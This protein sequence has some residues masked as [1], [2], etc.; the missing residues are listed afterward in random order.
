MNIALSRQA[1][2]RQHGFTLTE[3]M[4]T[5]AVMAVLAVVALPRLM[6]PLTEARMRSVAVEFVDS[7]SLARS[8]AASRRRTVVLCP[9]SSSTGTCQT[10][11]TNWNAGWLL[12]VD[13]NNNDTLDTTETR[14]L[15]HG[16]LPAALTIGGGTTGTAAIA[17]VPS[18]EAVNLGSATRTLPVTGTGSTTKRYVVIGRS[19]RASILDES[20]CAKTN[21]G[22]TP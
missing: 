2:F 14:L 20:Q 5:L 21:S 11:A 19:G 12:F 13:D 16:T 22:C 7:L 8:E 1:G 18:G 6:Q 17:V 15:S 10:G 9:R 4:T 3:L